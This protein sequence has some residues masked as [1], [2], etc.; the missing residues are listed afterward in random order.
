MTGPTE[1]PRHVKVLAAVASAVWM[2]FFLT[3]AIGAHWGWDSTVLL[4]AT[5]IVTVVALAAQARSLRT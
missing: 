2:A 4:V 3:I 1:Q 5:I